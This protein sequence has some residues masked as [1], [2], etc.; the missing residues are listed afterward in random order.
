MAL[1]LN[2]HFDEVRNFGELTIY[3]SLNVYLL[4]RV[5]LSAKQLH[6]L[7]DLQVHILNQS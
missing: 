2:K 7:V 4:G 3:D 1:I 6:I 5:V